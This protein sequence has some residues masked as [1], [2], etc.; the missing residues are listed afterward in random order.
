MD[1]KTEG[2][3]W[4]SVQGSC[5]VVDGLVYVGSRSTF[6]YAIEADTGKIRWRH[7]HDGGWVP[8]SPAVR[9]GIAYV[10]QSDGSKVTA[11]DAAG[12]TLWAFAAP[13]E[14]FASPALA[15]DVL[16]VGGNDNYD[17]RGKG[18]LSALDAKTGQVRWNLDLPAS[19]WASPVVVGDVVY[20]SCADGKVYAVK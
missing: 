10:G 17:S 4:N 11:V 14:T 16:Y 6:L 18:S 9:D 15:G 20:V 12:Q 19:V 3:L 8:S 5:A 7:G 2:V 1:T 13:H